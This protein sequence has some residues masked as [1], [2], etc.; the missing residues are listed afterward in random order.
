VIAN[1]IQNRNAEETNA[2]G[3]GTVILGIRLILIVQSVALAIHPR[4][5]EILVKIYLHHAY[6]LRVVLLI[7]IQNVAIQF[8]LLLGLI[9]A[10]VRALNIEMILEEIIAKPVPTVK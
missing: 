1:P 3:N 5:L 7:Q 9:D 4:P 2:S 8:L 6:L 10:A